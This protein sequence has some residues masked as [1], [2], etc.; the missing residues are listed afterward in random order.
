MRAPAGH[1]TSVEAA[2]E[3]VGELDHDPVRIGHIGGLASRPID[4]SVVEKESKPE[5]VN[6]PN[7]LV[8]VVDHK[9]CVIDVDVVGS[10]GRLGRLE[11][12]HVEPVAIAQDAPADAL[13]LP[14]LLDLARIEIDRLV[15]IADGNSHG[16]CSAR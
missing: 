14:P 2:A 3:P 6:A 16:R 11:K 4:R 10:E 13:A 9:P 15:E 7:G 5:L 12:T 1:T 8:D